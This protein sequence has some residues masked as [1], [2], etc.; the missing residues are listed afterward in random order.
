[1]CF[2]LLARLEQAGNLT[3]GG[4]MSN[5][6][7]ILEYAKN[8]GWIDLAPGVRLATREDLQKRLKQNHRLVEVSPGHSIEIMA[9]GTF[10]TAPY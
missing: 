4:N 3:F 10:D 9:E 8:A 7:E 5:A 6:I 1:L 2:A